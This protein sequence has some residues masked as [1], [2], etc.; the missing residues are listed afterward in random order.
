M[1]SNKIEYSTAAGLY[2]TMHDVKVPFYMPYLSSRKILDNRFDVKNYKGELGIGYDVIIGR[3]LMVQL[4]LPADFK[5]QVHQWNGAT[6]PM[7]EPSGL[8]GEL[9]LTSRDMREM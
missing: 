7:K 9:D 1:R 6:V 3:D 5:R 8:L 2:C 4:G